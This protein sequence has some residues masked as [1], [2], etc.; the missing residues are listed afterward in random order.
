MT[1]GSRSPSHSLS[2]VRY[3]VAISPSLGSVLC[4][5]LP[6]RYLKY[7]SFTLVLPFQ[8]HPFSFV[9][10]LT[11]AYC[12]ILIVFFFMVL[13]SQYSSRFT[14]VT[15]YRFLSS[16]S[17]YHL[18]PS[19]LVKRAPLSSHFLSLLIGRVIP[20]RDKII[21]CECGNSDVF[22]VTASFI[23]LTQSITVWHNMVLMGY[24]FSSYILTYSYMPSKCPGAG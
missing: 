1:G 8:R 5:I 16:H 3:S 13:H 11:F 22:E 18:L 9:F 10:L 21:D 7:S 6:W 12:F 23:S 19:L 24:S 14:G 4:R 17:L 2:P 20:S 15:G